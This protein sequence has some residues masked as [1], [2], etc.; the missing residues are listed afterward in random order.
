MTILQLDELLIKVRT[1]S[2]HFLAILLLIMPLLGRLA[3]FEW[4]RDHSTDI[5]MQPE[6]FGRVLD[7]NEHMDR[8]ERMFEKV[9]M[10]IL[11]GVL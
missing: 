3:R 11:A 1:T 7:Q 8:L 4:D 6:R 9:V 2:G 5:R 10:Y